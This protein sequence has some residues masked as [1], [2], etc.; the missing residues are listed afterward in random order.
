MDA[1][2][3]TSVKVKGVVA[4]ILAALFRTG[5]IATVDDGKSLLLRRAARGG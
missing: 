2:F 3:R 1:G 4:D 5:L